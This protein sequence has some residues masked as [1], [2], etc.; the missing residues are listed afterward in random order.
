[1]DARLAYVVRVD[2]RLTC[3]VY[4]WMRGSLCVVMVDMR[5]ACVVRVNTACLCCQD[6]CSDWLCSPG[7][8]VDRLRVRVDVRLASVCVRVDARLGCYV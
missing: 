1:M 5:L 6:G 7:E 4:G 3:V 8:C 2:V